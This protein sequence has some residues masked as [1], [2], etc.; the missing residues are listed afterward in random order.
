MV[1][2]HPRAFS[3]FQPRMNPPGHIAFGYLAARRRGESMSGRFVIGLFVGALTP[4]LI[5]K[6]LMFAGVYPWGRTVGHS[7]LVWA[8]FALVAALASGRG[9]VVPRAIAL[10]WATHFCADFLDDLAAGLMYDRY[11]VSAWFTWPYLNPDLYPLKLEESLMGPCSGCYT[12]IEAAV[13]GI[14]ILVGFRAQRGS[15]SES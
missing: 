12:A 6:S 11:T 9:A 5:D 1:N 8:L 3:Y 13:I 15:D 14:L 4:D 7:V 10:G 2:R